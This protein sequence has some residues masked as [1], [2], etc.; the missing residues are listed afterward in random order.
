[1]EVIKGRYGVATYAVFLTF[2]LMTNILVTAMLLCGGSAVA[3]HLS[4]VPTAAACFLL[5]ID[6]VLYTMFGGIKAT[7]LTDYV[8]TVI[9]FA[10]ILT[11][12][13]SAYATNATIGSPKRSMTCLS[14]PPPST[15]L[16]ATR[17]EAI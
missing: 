2:S 8:N 1:L 3:S 11:F 7:F 14:K 5:P 12:A 10:I 13:F 6:V 4:G 17:A 15:Q 9:I 16:R